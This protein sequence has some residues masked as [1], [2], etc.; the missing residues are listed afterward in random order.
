MNWFLSL[1]IEVK[2]AL[3]SLLVAAVVGLFTILQYFKST[4]SPS[5]VQQSID[6]TNNKSVQIN[7][8]NNGSINIK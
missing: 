4:K 5:Y 7:R 2:I 1:S 8:D 3:V 6:G